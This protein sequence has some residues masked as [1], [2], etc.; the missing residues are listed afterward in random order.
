V[1]FDEGHAP[2]RKGLKF[3]QSAI[4]VAE[5]SVGPIR[6]VI[7][8]GSV[9]PEMVPCHLNA[10]DCLALASVFEGSPNV[11][12]E[13]LACNVP[14]VATDVGDVSERLEEVFPSRVVKR[15]VVEFANALVEVLLDGRRSNGRQRV[16]ICSLPRVAEAIRSVYESSLRGQKLRELSFPAASTKG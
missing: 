13:A 6:L 3:L 4:H 10:S 11:V 5:Q 14:V 12:K 7:L 2:V 9:R 15:D 8:D 1:I 16:E